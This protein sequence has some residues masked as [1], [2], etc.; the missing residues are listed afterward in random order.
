MGASAHEAP[1]SF[2]APA[3]GNDVGVGMDEL[4]SATGL[5]FLNISLNQAHFPVTQLFPRK[6]QPTKLQPL[7]LQGAVH[8]H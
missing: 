5:E 3:V 2:P 6:R 4:P 8:V 1:A 7:G